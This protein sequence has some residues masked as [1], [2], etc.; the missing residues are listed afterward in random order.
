MKN[1]SRKHNFFFYFLG[2]K[3]LKTCFFKIDHNS[4]RFFCKLTSCKVPAISMLDG[5]CVIPVPPGAF[6]RIV[7]FGNAA[8]YSVSAK[9]E[10]SG[11]GTDH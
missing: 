2:V 9:V 4:H 1:P 5:T 10:N 3:N 8:E 6:G 11:F 7:G